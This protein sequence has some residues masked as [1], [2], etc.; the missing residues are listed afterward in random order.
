MSAF[1]DTLAWLYGLE[2]ARGMDF[3]LERTALALSALG[4]PHRQYPCVHIAGTNGKGSVA[5]MLHSILQAAGRRVGLYTSP[6]LVRFTERIRFGSEEIGED[7]VVELTN[8][9]RS[10]ATVRGIELTFFEFV[11]VIAFLAFARHGVDCAVVE[12]GLGGRLDATNVVDPEVAVITTIGR[13]HQQYLGDSIEEIAAE[14]GGIIKAGRPVVLGRMPPVANS[15][16]RAIAVER[17]AP[18]VESAREIRVDA[19]AELKISGLGWTL[20]GIRLALPGGFQLENARTA[21]AAAALVRDRWG[22]TDPAVRAGLAKVCWPG[23]FEVVSTVPLVIADGAHNEDGISML[24]EELPALIGQRPL[25]ALFAV[26]RDKNWQPMVE[27]LGPLLCSATIT[28]ALPPRGETPEVVA[29]CFRRYCQVTV[30]TDPVQ[31]LRQLYQR[32]P[33][34]SAL[35]VTGSLFLIGAV[36]PALR[37]GQGNIQ[38]LAHP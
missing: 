37:S 2:A 15:V 7:E 16:L 10:A 34:G 1:S 27:R 38:P 25:H 13:D 33:G 14:K 11:T 26:M 3:K 9:I 29:E 21:L 18:C 31:A 8:E 28:S 19:A 22:I 23:R 30:D 6:H 32:L 35:L 36:Y 12:V 5:A 4:D 20:E 24:V 17:G